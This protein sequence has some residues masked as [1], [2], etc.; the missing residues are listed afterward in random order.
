[1]CGAAAE[2]ILLALA[3]A[4]TCNEDAVIKEYRV[5]A[6]RKKTIDSLVG[7]LSF[8][9]QGQFRSLMRLLSYW[10][11]DA[12]H[13]MASPISAAEADEAMRQLHVLSQFADRHWA[14]LTT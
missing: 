4:K 5:P 10:R 13:G 6:G 1:M 12:A 14:E 8:G 7:Q 9:V 2:S 11:D 3:I